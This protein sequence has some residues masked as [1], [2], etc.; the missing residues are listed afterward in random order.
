MP[1]IEVIELRSPAGAARVT[2]G[3]SLLSNS[4]AMGMA[5]VL[6]RGLAY[7]CFILMARRLDA[8]YI[9]AYALLVTA[10]MIVELVSTLG[11]D[12][13]LIREIS[14]KPTAEGQ[15][16]FWAALPIRFVMATVSGTIAWALLLFFFKREQVVTPLETGVF[17]SAV[18]FAGV[19]RNCE[20]YLTAHERL[21]PVAI[22]QLS[23]R[24]VFFCAVLLLLSGFL[25]FGKM[26]CFVPLAAL[27]RSLIVARSTLRIWSRSLVQKRH[28][29]A[30]NLRVLLSPWLATA[31]VRVTLPAGE[32][33]EAGYLLWRR[34]ACHMN[35]AASHAQLRP[36]FRNAVELFSV[37]IL[38]LVYFRSDVFLLARMGGLRETAYYQVAYK[39]FDGCLSL[40]SG[41]L[42]ASFPRIV[43]DNSRA[44]LNNM[45]ALGTVLMTA[46]VAGVILARQQILS[47]LRPEYAAG[48]TSLVWLMLTVPLVYITSTLANA[49]IA[50]GRVQ[51]LI[52][53]AG[54]LLIANVSLNLI[55]IPRYSINGAAFSTFACE[56]L[57]AAILGPFVIRA[58]PSPR[59][60]APAE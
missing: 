42:L 59:T 56:L 22:A 50:A 41:L 60:A 38:A 19:S 48:A 31:P 43:R 15:S 4:F 45:L 44:N 34:W 8:R 21:S 57:S 29:T 12:K 11:L 17:L 40:F 14:A 39:V 6:G 30:C 24:I 2:P 47:A 16:Y 51:L 49:A 35:G 23:E 54:L 20:A 46:P 53:M 5:N 33:A 25:T 1:E 9:G 36:L 55:L 58:L 26:L 27:V 32:I 28:E 18:L 7:V 3:A 37:E 10:G 13:I 52:L